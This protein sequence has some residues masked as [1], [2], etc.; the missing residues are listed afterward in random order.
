[1]FPVRPNRIKHPSPDFSRTHVQQRVHAPQVRDCT[2]GRFVNRVVLAS[3]CPGWFVWVGC[4]WAGCWCGCV[5]AWCGCAY[6]PTSVCFALLLR[7][8]R[9]CCGG[10]QRLQLPACRAPPLWS[11][12]GKPQRPSGAV[13]A[14]QDDTT[15][16]K[17]AFG[18]V[19]GH[20]WNHRASSRRH[21]E[22]TQ[23]SG[24]WS[25]FP[26]TA[27]VL[28]VCVC[29]RSGMSGLGAYQ[30]WVCPVCPG[31]GRFAQV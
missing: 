10:S 23:N 24:M 28:D 11:H 15:E 29:A 8:S 12:I 17:P 3:G 9:W 18:M 30:G 16:A 20:F 6:R 1:M 25:T 21:Q 2:M 22:K 7:S 31:V 19:R 4:V 13:R 27:L 26:W 14:E 5:W